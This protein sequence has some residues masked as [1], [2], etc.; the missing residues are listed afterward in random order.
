MPTV[1]T[2]RTNLIP[3]RART[4]VTPAGA[5]NNL[6]GEGLTGLEELDASWIYLG[7]TAAPTEIT[8]S[9]EYYE[10]EI[11]QLT[12]RAV[13]P[14]TGRSLTASLELAEATPENLRILLNQALATLSEV[15]ATSTDPG[16]TRLD[17]TGTADVEWRV[18]VEWEVPGTEFIGRFYIPLAKQTGDVGQ[19]YS[20]TGGNNSTVEF[21]AL[22]ED[23]TD[24]DETLAYV[25]TQTAEPTGGE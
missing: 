19:V 25:I 8:V 20:K 4:Y 17:I 13:A 18:C 2:K 6:I 21:S 9:S 12:T 3:L 10:P 7:L 1:N 22:L 5:E 15:A 11:E 14:I 23:L 16:Y 24:P